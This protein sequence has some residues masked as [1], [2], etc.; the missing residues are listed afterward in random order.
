MCSNLTRK[1]VEYEKEKDKETG[2]GGGNL[3]KREENEKGWNRLEGR[4]SAS[5]FSL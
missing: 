1:G 4:L 3:Y 5:L 2:R